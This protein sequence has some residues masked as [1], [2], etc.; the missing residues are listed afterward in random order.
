M[1]DRLTLQ[2]EQGEQG[3]KGAQGFV[4]EEGECVVAGTYLYICCPF[5]MFGD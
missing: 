4:G 2:G 1:F 3:G 5:R